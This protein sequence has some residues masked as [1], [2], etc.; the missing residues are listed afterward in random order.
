MNLILRAFRFETLV[1]V[2]NTQALDRQ[3]VWAHLVVNGKIRVLSTFCLK[4][5]VTMLI[6]IVPRFHTV[7]SDKSRDLALGYA[8]SAV[9]NTAF[10]LVSHGRYETRKVINPMHIQRR[11][12]PGANKGRREVISS[13]QLKKILLAW[14]FTEPFE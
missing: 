10:L 12:Q 8:S 5:Q 9:Q 6:S 3:T 2:V 1:A 4:L 14:F 13:R 11:Q 7:V